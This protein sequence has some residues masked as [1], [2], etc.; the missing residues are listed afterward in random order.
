ML[1]QFG[2]EIFMAVNGQDAVDKA[3]KTSYDLI[4]MDV[5]MP[6]MNGYEA[7][8]EIR[9]TG[10]RVPIIAMTANAMPEDIKRAKEAGMNDHIAKPLDLPKMIETIRRV[11][12]K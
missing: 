8:E 12:P 9:K 3:A 10:S 4:L 11:L 6:V 7:S 2:F 1:E 5:Q